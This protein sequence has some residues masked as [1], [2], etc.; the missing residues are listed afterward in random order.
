MTPNEPIVY[1]VDDDEPMRR[2]LAFLL[3]G[4]G[5]HAETFAS[6]EAL[7][8]GFDPRRPGCILLD[9]RMSGMD[10]LQLQQTLHTRGIRLPVIIISGFAD[11]PS[12]VQ[13][14]KNGA[15]DVLEKP[16]ERELLLERVRGAIERDLRDRHEHAERTTRLAKLS[17][18]QRE[19][20]QRLLS[21]KGTK[22]IA[23]DMGI[24]TKTLEKHRAQV[25]ERMGVDSVVELMRMMLDV[26]PAEEVMNDE[27]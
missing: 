21:G 20:M 18:R 17:N 14:V 12:V 22:Q 1:I 4:A 24:S 8:A 2:S 19:V 3:N 26:P 7:L 25:L 16:F 13:A 11:I 15:I 27:R 10:G 5:L 23:H 9:L 6:A